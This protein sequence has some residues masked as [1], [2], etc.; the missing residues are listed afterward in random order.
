MYCMLTILINMGKWIVILKLCL[1]NV[2]D[3]QVV[4]VTLVSLLKPS[5]QFVR[6]KWYLL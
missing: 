5:R 2:D 3:W 1:T 4:R 6:G